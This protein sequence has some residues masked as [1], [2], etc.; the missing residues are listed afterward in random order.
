MRQNASKQRLCAIIGTLASLVIVPSCTTTNEDHGEVPA[1]ESAPTQTPSPTEVSKEAASD[2]STPAYAL[3]SLD[4]VTSGHPELIADVSDVRAMLNAANKAALGDKAGAQAAWFEALTLTSSG[5]GKMALTGWLKAYTDNLGHKSDPAVLARLITAETR[6]GSVSP[7]MLAK[8]LTN[9]EA[10]LPLLQST[11]P[12]W[13]TAE[14]A[15]SPAKTEA[16]AEVSPPHLATLPDGDPLLHKIAVKVCKARVQT[17]KDWQV[18]SESLTA[19]VRAY[20]QA[21]LADN[22]G[23][24]PTLAIQGYQQAYPLL[25]AQPQTLG[26]AIEA[27]GR[28]AALQRANGLRTEAAATYSALVALWSKSGLLPGALGLSAQAL[29]L[30]RIDETLWA[31]RYRALVGDYE[32]AKVFAQNALDQTKQMAIR[33]SQ[34]KPQIRE[35]IAS[36]RADAYHTLAFRVAVEQHQFTSA[37]S[38]TLL[39]LD[40][41]DLAKDWHERLTWNAGLYDYLDGNFAGARKRWSTLLLET[42]EEWLQATLKFWLARTSAKLGDQ[43]GS[44]AQVAALIHEHPLSYYAVVACKEAGLQDAAPQW[45]KTFGPLSVLSQTLALA[46]D[47]Q[48]QTTRQSAILRPLLSRAEILTAANLGPFAR[49]AVNELEQALGPIGD[50]RQRA[51]LYVYLSR[52]HFRAGNYLAAINITTKLA[53]QVPDFWQAWPDQ[54]LVYFAQPF[55]AEY[56]YSAEASGVAKEVLLGIS[57]QESGFTPDIR[58]S[59]NATGLMQLIAPTARRFATELGMR[60]DPLDELLQEPATNIRLGAHYLKFLGAHFKGFPPAIYAGYNAGEYAVDLWLQRRGHSDPLAFIELIPFGETKD[61]VK[62][63]WRNVLVYRELDQAGL[64]QVQPGFDLGFAGA[65]GA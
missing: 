5:F 40:T 33:R 4:R 49:E 20:W 9:V 35:Q 24:G 22:C 46:H 64:S 32:H 2:P 15:P 51:Q 37:L 21:L 18:W 45:S 48:L 16:K 61:Y 52:L 65:V 38:L 58:S 11:V 7:Y 57:R 6:N 23:L 29:S 53:K 63:V 42:Q 28:L 54:L 14:A 41:P 36:L 39:G 8:N 62:G 12:Q 60:T 34:F 43:A 25:A 59:A 19:E 27:T 17:S 47:F 10:I 3:R 56:S 13:L 26:M 50:I 30:R 44:R 31:A 1:A 55:T